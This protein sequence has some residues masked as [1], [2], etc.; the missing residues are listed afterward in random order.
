M[1]QIDENVATNIFLSLKCRIVLFY[2]DA[3]S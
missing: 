3:T 2:T 1:Y